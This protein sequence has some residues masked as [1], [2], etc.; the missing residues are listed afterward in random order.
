MSRLDRV[1]KDLCLFKTRTQA[2][3]ACKEGRV[4]VDGKPARASMSL[5][6]GQ[7]IL[8]RDRLGLRETELEILRV[9]E[10]QVPRKEVSSYATITVRRDSSLP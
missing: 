6:S 1:L 5:H 3:Q 4:L 2:T 8:I 10:R 9:P 7:K